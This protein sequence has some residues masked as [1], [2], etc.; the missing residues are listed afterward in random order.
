MLRSKR[1][2]DKKIKKRQTDEFVLKRTRNRYFWNLVKGEGMEIKVKYRSKDAS[3]RNYPITC[4]AWCNKNMQD[5]APLREDNA[6]STMLAPRLIND[7]VK[8][9][10]FILTLTS[11]TLFLS[12][13]TK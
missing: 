2:A 8:P 10:S 5:S 12:A 9:F 4:F 11:I 6:V 7:L 13:A 1:R 3:A